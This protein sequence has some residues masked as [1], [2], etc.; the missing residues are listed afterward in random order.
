MNFRKDSC[1]AGVG[2]NSVQCLE[3]AEMII[4][5]VEKAETFSYLI[6]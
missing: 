4:S 1:M 6:L 5:D 3:D 2:L